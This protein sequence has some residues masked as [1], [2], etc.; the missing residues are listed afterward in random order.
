MDQFNEPI[1]F[2]LKGDK[3]A[4]F[5]WCFARCHQAFNLIYE[6]EQK[7]GS[8]WSFD[9]RYYEYGIQIL[10][11][12]FCYA[13]G[14]IVDQFHIE[15][16]AL[17]DA[18]DARF[19]SLSDVQAET[20]TFEVFLSG[21]VDEVFKQYTRDMGCHD[22]TYKYYH[23]P[24]YL[25]DELCDEYE[26]F[27]KRNKAVL[28]DIIA[29]RENFSSEE[30]SYLYGF[31]DLDYDNT[32]NLDCLHMM[33]CSKKSGGNVDVDK[34]L[35]ATKRYYLPT[36]IKAFMAT[37]KEDVFSPKPQAKRWQFWKR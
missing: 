7:N 5:K 32:W 6:Y 15:C 33:R 16:V 14:I 28:L 9:D 24:D 19:K 27:W 3:E 37:P 10:Y 4:L 22:A 34:F 18:N 17:Q 20:T 26:N 23:D 36:I 12:R 31:S 29:V 13:M 25:D 11:E 2:A 21:S 35:G 30:R 1:D 8:F